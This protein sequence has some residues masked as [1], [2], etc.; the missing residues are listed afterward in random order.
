VFELSAE[1]PNV[2]IKIGT[3]GELSVVYDGLTFR[4]SKVDGAVRINNHSAAAG[5]VLHH[6]CL[7]SFGDRSLGSGQQWVTFTS[8]HPEVVL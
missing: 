5:C 3:L 6:A 1:N 7:L 2:N 4:I 8:S